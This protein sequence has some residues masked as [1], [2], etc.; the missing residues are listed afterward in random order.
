MSEIIRNSYEGFPVHLKHF[1]RG[2]SI[3]PTVYVGGAFQNIDRIQG[4]CETLAEDSWVIAV[5][6][7]GNGDTGVLP[8]KFDFDFI[9]QAIHFA[10]KETGV[11]RFHMIG[12][13]YGTMIAQRYSQMYPKT[14]IN[15]TLAAAMAEP[16]RALLCKFDLMI[17]L[18]EWDQK[19]EFANEFC[20]LMTTPAFRD[21]NRLARLAAGKL[22]HSLINSTLG[23][24]EQFIHNTRRIINHGRID[25]SDMPDIPVTVMVGEHDIFTPLAENEKVAAAFNQSN[26]I[27]IKNADHM[28]HVEKRKEYIGHLRAARTFGLHHGVDAP[29]TVSEQ[30]NGAGFD[31]VVQEVEYLKSA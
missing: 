28:L 30:K 14:L 24:Y 16:S 6:T 21:K 27:V 25:L 20:N 29:H 9:C 10:L 3:Y 2:T 13:S 11:D 5:D 22:E 19:E 31:C 18:I 7:P 8:Y 12:T 1:G 23:I 26:L 15:L 4:L 17:A